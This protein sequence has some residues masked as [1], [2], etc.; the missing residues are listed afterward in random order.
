MTALPKDIVNI[1]E[2]YYK[3]EYWIII[4]QNIVHGNY[5]LKIINIVHKISEVII[6][7]KNYILNNYTYSNLNCYDDYMISRK[8]IIKVGKFDS[9]NKFPIK[10]SS[11]RI[12]TE[13]D[14]GEFSAF[15]HCRYYPELDDFPIH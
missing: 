3:K 11:I 10:L 9:K 7:I 12:Q 4:S 8:E 5:E 1:I 2:K 6:C 13:S 14:I 15:L